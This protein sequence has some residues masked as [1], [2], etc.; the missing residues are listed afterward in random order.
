MQ[1]KNLEQHISERHT[2]IHQ[3]VVTAEQMRNIESRIFLSGMPVPALMEKVGGLIAQRI[4]AFFPCQQTS[5][6][7]LVGPG[8]N[9]G[10]ALVVAR[11]LYFQGYEV[12]VCRPLPRAKELTEQHAQY[13]VSLGVDMSQRIELLQQCDVVVDGLFGFGLERPIEGA[14]ADL[15]HQLNTWSQPIVS[16]DL[17][18]GLH[19]DTGAV[20]GTAIQATYTLC[21]GLWK[22]GLLQDQSLP[23]SGHLHLIDFDIPVADINAVLGDLP[24]IRRITSVTAKK[25]LPTQRHPNTHKYRQGHCLLIGGSQKYAGSILLTALGAR[26]TGVGMIT[27]A[28]PASLK[29]LVLQSVP[30]ALVIACPETEQGAI[31]SLPSDLLL[32]SFDAIA[33]GPG[34][35]TE[36]DAILSE[37]LNCACPLVLDADGLN[38]LAQH[39]P[40]EIL[41]A[42]SAPTILTPHPGEFKR[43]FP[44]HPP[45]DILQRVRQA[46]Q[47][48]NAY[49]IYKGARVM[50]APPQGPLWINPDSTPALARG[51][52]GDVL[53]GILAGLL[54]QPLEEHSFSEVLCSGIWW[55]A[56]AGLF[57]ARQRTELGVDPL[58]LCKSLIP[59][60]A[61][62]SP[63]NPL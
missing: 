54:S 50:L 57:A 5:V 53:T 51:G 25:E 13:V 36:T 10:D 49:I 52:S 22:L 61:R 35:T 43:L 30:E 18:S 26:A 58:T 2:Q 62:Q 56:Q 4:Q 42:R 21:L 55:H 16:I 6:G 45:Q 7:I 60:I 33:Y 28:V 3:T 29:P 27:I 1:D 19:T 24:D 14:I 31:A 32:D 40:F 12:H 15:I 38:L 44:A 20:L 47:A 34:I 23:Y 41:Q 63:K 59:T 46:A 17:P 37:V 48:S 11:E 39:Q 9:G 8:H